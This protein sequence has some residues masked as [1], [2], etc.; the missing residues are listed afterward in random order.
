MLRKKKTPDLEKGR[1]LFYQYYGNKFGMRHDLDDAY[2]RCRV[3]AGMEK[4]WRADIINKLEAEMRSA[5]GAALEIAVSRYM[6]I[7]GAG[8]AWLMHFLQS[9]ET[10]TFTAVILCEQLKNSLGGKKNRT[11][12][13][14]RRF[15]DSFRQKLLDS[16]VTIDRSYYALP[17]IE[18]NL[19]CKSAI[20]DRIKAI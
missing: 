20:K 17:Y 12:S 3:P 13:R 7:K 9:R 14:I 4:K 2:D 16:P 6:H 15:L 18:K 10:D 19:L 5:C 8:P 1:E 11:A